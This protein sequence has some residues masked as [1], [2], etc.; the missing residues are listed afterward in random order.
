MKS[1]IRMSLG[2]SR[3][4]LLRQA[5]LESALLA[6]FGALLGAALA[7]P[8]SRALVNSLDTSQNTI[9]STIVAGLARAFVCRGRS[10]YRDVRGFR[11]ASCL[12]QHRRGAAYGA[13]S[14]ASAGWLATASDSLRSAHW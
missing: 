11:H 3:G 7:Q 1:A 5:L 2:A 13:E 4:R 6:T 9:I 12:T 14:P 10:R 8:L